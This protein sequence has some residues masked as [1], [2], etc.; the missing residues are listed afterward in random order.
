MK[1]SELIL[2]LEK[3]KE[4]DGDLPVFVCELSD[5]DGDYN[6]REIDSIILGY[7]DDEE[8]KSWRQGV[9]INGD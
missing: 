3:I 5:I 4:K 7:G 9:V 6:N 8:T 1:I 2:E